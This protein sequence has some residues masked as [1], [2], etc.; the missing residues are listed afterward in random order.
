VLLLALTSVAAGCRGDVAVNPETLAENASFAWKRR[1]T[2]RALYSGH[3]LSDGVPEAVA[4]IASARRQSLE[5]EVQSASYSLLSSRPPSPLTA[6]KRFDAV[7]VT[8]RHDLPWVAATEG[9]ATHLAEYARRAWQANP[10]TDVFFYHTW[11]ALDRAAPAPWIAYEQ[12]AVR[13]W[14]CVASRANRDLGGGSNRIR[15]LPGGAALA[16]LVDLLWKGQVPGITTASPSARVGLLL[17]DDVH[18]SA[19]GRYYMGLVHY[20]FLFG[21]APEGTAM[22]GVADDTRAFLEELAYQKAVAYARVANAA[23]A[24]DMEACR[25]FAAEEM[26]DASYALPARGLRDRLTAP[27]RAWRCRRLYEDPAAPGNPFGNR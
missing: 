11:L 5:F 12:K 10:A 27:Y 4:A 7:V 19:I 23:G 13:L 2:V 8:E 18:L 21:Q 15:V 9:T 3:S 22:Q 20:A 1:E 14:E 25:V 26:C 16:D 6:E 17:A 24:R